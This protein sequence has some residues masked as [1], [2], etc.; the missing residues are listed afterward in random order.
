M[1]RLHIQISHCY[2]KVQMLMNTGLC[3]NCV[4]VAW[5]NMIQVLSAGPPVASVALTRA[6]WED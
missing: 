6:G 3:M 4:P 5:N 1:H 2:K